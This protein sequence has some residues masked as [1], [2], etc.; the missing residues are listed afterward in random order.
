VLV[1][2]STHCLSCGYWFLSSCNRHILAS[3]LLL[4][5]NLRWPSMLVKCTQLNK[6]YLLAILLQSIHHRVTKSYV[7][8]ILLPQC[9]VEKHTEQWMNFKWQVQCWTEVRHK[10]LFLSNKVRFRLSRNKSWQEEETLLFSGA[11][12]LAVKP[13]H[14]HRQWPPGVFLHAQKVAK[15]WQI[16]ML[17]T[18]FHLPLWLRMSGATL[19]LP[20]MPSWFVQGAF[21]IHCYDIHRCGCNF[22]TR[23][24]WH[25]C[26]SNDSHFL[27]FQTR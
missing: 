6:V 2:Q 27:E 13:T 14:H 22:S 12:E 3:H 23:R 8:T 4:Y 9:H 11:S 21:T 20:H 18:H 10:H 24:T 16:M 1:S 15:S 19:P 17:T 26:D 7:K 5:V 25:A